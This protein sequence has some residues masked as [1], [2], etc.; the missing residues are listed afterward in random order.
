M[1]QPGGDDS[2]RADYSP[3]RGV[4]DATSQRWRWEGGGQMR[5]GG[6]ENAKWW[7]PNA[8]GEKKSRHLQILAIGGPVPVCPVPPIFIGEATSPMNICHLYSSVMWL[9][10]RI[11]GASQSQT[12]RSIYSSVSDPNRRI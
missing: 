12:G 10:R 11:Y 2:G 5:G 8:K 3:H 6:V 9:H 4:D 1:T 7:H